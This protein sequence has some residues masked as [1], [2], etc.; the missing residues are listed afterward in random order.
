LFCDRSHNINE[1]SVDS[2]A[3]VFGTLPVASDLP[4]KSI[5]ISVYKPA[6]RKNKRWRK[7]ERVII[8]V[9][10][11]FTEVVLLFG[12]PSTGLIMGRNVNREVRK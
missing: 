11:R 10:R 9:S 6:K 8:L 5:D 7:R 1:P 3:R 4:Q 2:G 12:R